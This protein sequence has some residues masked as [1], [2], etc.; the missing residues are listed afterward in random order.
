[1]PARKAAKKSVSKSS[2][3]PK[4]RYAPHPALAMIQKW[5]DELPGKS[6]RSLGQWMTMVKKQGLK[7]EKAAREWLKKEHGMSTSSAGY[8]AER[9]FAAPGSMLEEDPDQYLQIAEQYV[10]DMFAGGKAGLKPIYDK[11]LDLG[12]S[13]APD[14]KACPCKTI[15]PFYREHVIAQIKPSTRTRIDL[16]FALA[17]HKG[18]LPARLI[19]TGGLAKKDRITHRIEITSVDDI[20]KD[21]EKWLKVAYDLDA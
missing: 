4:T 9:A 1:M 19:D 3:S 15:V 20:D 6:G 12:L 21:V 17:R 2:K 8:I 5:I 14:V 18:K 7:D 13:I 11:L 16:G 10:A